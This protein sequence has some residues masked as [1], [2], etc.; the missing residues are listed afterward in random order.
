MTAD[1][2]PGDPVSEVV[3]EQIAEARWKVDVRKF[4]DKPLVPHLVKLT[5]EVHED[6]QRASSN[7]DSLIVCAG[8]QLK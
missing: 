2:D 3:L 5:L 6:S 1:T 4:A 8:S 7:V